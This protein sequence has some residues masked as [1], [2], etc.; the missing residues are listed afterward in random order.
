LGQGVVQSVS[1][2]ETGEEV[3]SETITTETEEPEGR[4]S[5]LARSHTVGE[6]ET[7]SQIGENTKL[8]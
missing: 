3:V 7:I 8:A 2:P 1:N 6:G 5:E 4:V